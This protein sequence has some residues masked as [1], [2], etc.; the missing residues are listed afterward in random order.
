MNKESLQESIFKKRIH[1]A[2]ALMMQ[3]ALGGMIITPSSDLFYLTGIKPTSGNFFCALLLSPDRYLWLAPCSP[4]FCQ[5][6]S[7]FIPAY[8]YETTDDP[9]RLAI[10]W[11]GDSRSIIVPPSIPTTWF[12]SLKDLLPSCQWSTDTSPL[13]LLRMV[14]DPDELSFIKTAQEMTEQAIETVINHGL[15]GKTEKQTAQILMELRLEIGFDSVGPGLIASGPNTA[16]PHHTPTD[17]II[18]KG[19]IV[20]IDIGGEYKGYHADMTRS[21]IV[22]TA[23]S[24]IKEVYKIVLDA[25]T[26][27]QKAAASGISCSRIDQAGRQVI[28]SAGYGHYFTHGIGHGI[29]LDVHEEP[30]L[31]SS[32]QQQ[33]F[34]GMVFSIEPG[35]YIPGAF[36]IRIEDLFTIQE[37]GKA[38]DFNHMSRALTEIE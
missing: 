6:S 1:Q 21:F 8:F 27:A 7:A 17:R 22:G 28:R 12:L 24:R 26:A 34:P 4:A 23:S 33:L 29:G 3:N 5:S 18:R 32:S 16:S 30:F 37:N 15:A 14:K 10:Q 25:F 35:I 13:K 11:L 9:F 20:T 31:S 36:G 2:Q 38:V 19:D